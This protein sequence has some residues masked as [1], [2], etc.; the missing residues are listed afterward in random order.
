[1]SDFMNSAT[2]EIQQSGHIPDFQPP[3]WHPITRAEHDRIKGIEKHYRE[4]NGTTIVEMDAAA[5]TVVDQ[6]RRDTACIARIE[7]LNPALN[8]V[9]AIVDEMLTVMKNRHSGPVGGIARPT[10]ATDLTPGAFRNEVK[11]KLNDL[12][13]GTPD[14]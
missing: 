9:V 10:P 6:A 12:I 2:L 5:K 4:W 8:A 7:A 1:M 3:D 14:S 11:R 13:D